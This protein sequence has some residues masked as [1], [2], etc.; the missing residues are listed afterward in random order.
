MAIFHSYVC[1]PEGKP[2]TREM[3][4]ISKKTMGKSWAKPKLLQF[5][6]MLPVKWNMFGDIGPISDK[7]KLLLKLCSISSQSLQSVLHD[8]TPRIPWFLE[9]HVLHC[10]PWPIHQM[11]T[12]KESKF[13]GWN[14]RNI[15]MI[16]SWIWDILTT[17]S[18]FFRTYP[19]RYF[20][21]YVKWP[22]KT[23]DLPPKDSDVPS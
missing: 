11:A 20:N 23:V 9:L 13:S 17:V 1:L 8:S 22:M 5:I 4:W 7:S 21:R 18:Q 3:L 14:I 2:A 19:V 10:P 12:E 6:I 15:P 16:G